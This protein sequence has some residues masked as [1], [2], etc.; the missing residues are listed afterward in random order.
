MLSLLGDKKQ[1]YLGWCYLG[2]TEL[3][4]N[5]LRFSQQKAIKTVCGEQEITV[6]FARTE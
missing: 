6:R 2:C 5:G 3:K 4:E 1:R